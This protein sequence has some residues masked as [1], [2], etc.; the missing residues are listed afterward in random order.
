MS[1]R[2]R[3]DEA[4][5]DGVVNEEKETG[6]IRFLFFMGS[7]ELRVSGMQSGRKI[8]LS[9]PGY[10]CLSP[11]T[12]RMIHANSRENPRPQTKYRI[13]NRRLSVNT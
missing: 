13:T 7:E 6:E 4:Q 5:A 11:C 12:F 10:R 8:S 1:S 3:R 2:R 9:N